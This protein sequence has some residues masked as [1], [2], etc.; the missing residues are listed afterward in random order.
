MEANLVAVAVEYPQSRRRQ[1]A[2]V[3]VYHNTCMHATTYILTTAKS[4]HNNI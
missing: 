2:I 4:I 3:P 1:P